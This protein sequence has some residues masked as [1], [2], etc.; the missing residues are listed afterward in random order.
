MV[1]VVVEGVAAAAVMGLVAVAGE[2]VIGGTGAAEL[3][4]LGAITVVNKGIWP[5]TVLVLVTAAEA[6]VVGVSLAVR[7]DT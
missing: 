5:E 7:L 2:A 1:V 4:G 6:A 3:V